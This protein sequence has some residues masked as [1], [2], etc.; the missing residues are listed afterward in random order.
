MTN[1]SEFKE[2]LSK[3][4]ESNIN[5]AKI[6]ENILV[7]I[8]ILFLSV[9]LFTV[10]SKL[11]FHINPDKL[12]QELTYIFNKTLFNQDLIVSTI[13]AIAYSLITALILTIFVRYRVVF[14]I[15]IASF[16]LLDGLGVFVYYNVTIGEK[17]FVIFGAIYYAIYTA[18]IIVS[19][20]LFR[21]LGYKNED[22]IELDKYDKSILED[23]IMELRDTLKNI[24]NEYSQ[25]KNI[26]DKGFVNTPEDMLK[27]KVLYLSRE[28]KLTQIEIADRVGISQPQVSR[29]L[30]KSKSG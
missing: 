3:K 8:I 27:E 24:Q 29:I 4:T 28:K 9:H 12:V 21:Y 7:S 20:S 16:A 10:H 26:H 18:S 22:L 2:R 6:F 1:Y 17:L 13:G 25:N 5:W 14:I 23:D 19:L 30:Q 15:T 11:L